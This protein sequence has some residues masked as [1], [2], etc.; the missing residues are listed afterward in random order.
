[1]LNEQSTIIFRQRSLCPI[2]LM[3]K[4][5]YHQMA[6]NG[7]TGFKG[8]KDWACADQM[9]VQWQ[10]AEHIIPVRQPEINLCLPTKAIAKRHKLEEA[11]VSA[12]PIFFLHKREECQ[13]WR[14]TWG[15]RSICCNQ[16]TIPPLTYHAQK[17]D[18][19]HTN[20]TSV[21]SAMPSVMGH[22]DPQNDKKMTQTINKTLRLCRDSN[23]R[24][25]NNESWRFQ[26]LK[27]EKGDIEACHIQ[28]HITN[29]RDDKRQIHDDEQLKPT[30]H[31]TSSVHCKKQTQLR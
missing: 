14:S 8:R 18:P 3:V 29:P 20:I 30:N 15:W 16:L 31:S 4:N 5:Q 6:S 12:F 21:N 10:L 7:W 13:G 11:C 19:K 24:K 22:I 23:I 25:T 26:M 28:P 9:T 1:M 17:L 27:T 2:R